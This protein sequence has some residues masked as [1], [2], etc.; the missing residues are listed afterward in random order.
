MIN[1]YAIVS[2]RYEIQKDVWIPKSGTTK[3]PV[4]L[5]IY[6]HKAQ[7]SQSIFYGEPRELPLDETFFFVY[8]GLIQN[9]TLEPHQ[10]NHMRGVYSF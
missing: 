9:Q 5:E 2:A 3:Q 10:T 6:H 7:C 1:F 4:E 8:F